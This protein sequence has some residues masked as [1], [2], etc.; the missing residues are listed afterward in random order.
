[1]GLAF[2]IQRISDN[3]KARY[4]K[5]TFATRIKIEWFGIY[6]L[7]SNRIERHITYLCLTLILSKGY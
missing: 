5:E 1:M 3:Q 2:E 7:I 6:L 4:E